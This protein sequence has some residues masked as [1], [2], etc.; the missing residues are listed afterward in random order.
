[1]PF[2]IYNTPAP[3]GAKSVNLLGW[4]LGWK[5]YSIVVIA[6]A[7]IWYPVIFGASWSPQIDT[8]I[9]IT[10]GL[11]GVGAARSALKSSTTAVVDATNSPVR[12][13]PAVAPIGPPP[14]PIVV[15]P[16]SGVPIP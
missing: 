1:M 12:T 16:V 10:L 8:A 11:L 4:L 15:M 13:I 3:V 6:I 9:N 7:K 14:E 2:G 5:T